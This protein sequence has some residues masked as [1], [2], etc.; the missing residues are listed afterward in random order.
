[1]A[2]RYIGKWGGSPDGDSPTLWMDDETGEY[3]M[4]GYE[5]ASPAVRSELLATAGKDAVPAGETLIRW[6][7]DMAAFFQEVERAG[8][9]DA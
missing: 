4:Q 5:V 6:P 9:T 2:I 1:M 3:Y 7:A 8:G